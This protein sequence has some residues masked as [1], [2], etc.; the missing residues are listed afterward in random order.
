MIASI[1]DG[2]YMALLGLFLVIS[3][4]LWFQKNAAERTAANLQVEKLE[5][6]N[7]LFAEKIQ[8]HGLRVAM[9]VLEKTYDRLSESL[10]KEAEIE[11]EINDAPAEDDAPVAPVLRR[12]LDGVGRMLHN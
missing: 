2:I 8:V 12:A 9:G 11:K 6:E 3:G 5:L 10:Q 4:F 7:K 1:K